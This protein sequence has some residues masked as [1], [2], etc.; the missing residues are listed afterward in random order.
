MTDVCEKI[1]YFYA[2]QLL[3]W[4][5]LQQRLCVLKASS[6]TDQKNDGLSFAV[7]CLN[8]QKDNR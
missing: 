4:G 8:E 5:H 7:D 2:N 6:I 3:I 1:K